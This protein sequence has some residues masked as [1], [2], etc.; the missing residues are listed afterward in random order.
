MLEYIKERVGDK[1][2]TSNQSPKENSK[3][4]RKALFEELIAKNIFHKCILNENYIRGFISEKKKKCKKEHDI[5]HRN[6]DR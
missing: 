1:K 4:K 6:R 2:D 3:N 5:R